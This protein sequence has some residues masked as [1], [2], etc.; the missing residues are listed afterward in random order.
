MTPSASAAES[1]ELFEQNYNR[2]YFLS[3]EKKFRERYQNHWKRRIE[4]IFKMIRSL[5]LSG[6]RVLDLGSSIGT[7]TI[8]F[9][10]RGY[11]AT[12]IDLSS[13]AVEKAQQLALE[14]HAE[15]QFRVGDITQKY[16]FPAGT[17][18]L[19]YAGDI[20]EHLLPDA[21]DQTLAHC[22]YWLKEGGYFVYHTVP[23]KY[24]IVFHKSPLWW[25]LIPFVPFPE[26]VFKAAVQSVYRLYDRLYFMKHGIGY[27]KKQES[28]V[29]CNLQTKNGFRET[30]KKNGFKSIQQT[31]VTTEPR[32]FYGIKKKLFS[33][34]EDYLK[35][36]FGVAQA[37]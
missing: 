37:S 1:H 5:P 33:K 29:H 17:F 23:L 4:I 6:K 21:L 22:R 16:H 14:H 9:A 32:F 12:G 15:A 35:D 19:I 27:I 10:L 2:Q 13:L 26:K 25:L 3:Q 34:K 7:Y 30:L 28:M 8:E 18:D 24:D 31:L 36:L 20:I 11:Q